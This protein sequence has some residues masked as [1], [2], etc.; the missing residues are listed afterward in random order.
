[1]KKFL[2]GVF[3][4]I[5]GALASF[6]A[7]YVVTKRKYD[8]EILASDQALHG[9]MASSEDYMSRVIEARERITKDQTEQ[10]KAEFMARFGVKS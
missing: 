8:I 4:G 1:M 3:F 9:I 10:V 6:A 5:I 7:W 2:Y